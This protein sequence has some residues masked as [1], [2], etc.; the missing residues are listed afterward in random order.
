MGTTF[1]YFF[2]RLKFAYFAYLDIEGTLISHL[3]KRSDERSTEYICW[4]FCLEA[5]FSITLFLFL[6]VTILKGFSRGFKDLLKSMFHTLSIFL[7][8]Y[9]L[10]LLDEITT[11]ALEVEI[12][13]LCLN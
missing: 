10:G 5:I 3:Y 8:S 7:S 2:E 9:F 6:F 11:L 4:S 13:L 1:V 12:E